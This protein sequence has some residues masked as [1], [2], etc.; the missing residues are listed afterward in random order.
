MHE[1]KRGRV[2]LFPKQEKGASLFDDDELEDGQERADLPNPEDEHP[3]DEPGLQL[4]KPCFKTFFRDFK[5]RFLDRSSTLSRI[6]TKASEPSSVSRS[7][8]IFGIEMRVIVY[9][10][11][12]IQH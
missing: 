8:R 10:K 3:L 9:L 11:T 5:S 12:N 7:R 1:L 4:G 6:W 2:D